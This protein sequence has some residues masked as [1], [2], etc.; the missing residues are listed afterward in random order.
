MELRTR[1]LV[2]RP[3]GRGDHAVLV[4]I[5]TDPELM[6]HIHTGVPH[7]FDECSDDLE[8]AT[9]AWD[10]DGFGP[11]VAELADGTLI[12]T[13]GFGRP[14]WCPEAMPGP[15]VGWTVLQ[16]H[17]RRGYATE[18]AAASI[19]WF[20]RAGL[21][22]HLVGIHNTDNPASG[23]VMRRLGMRWLRQTIHPQC[24]YPIELWETTPTAWDEAQRRLRPSD[25]HR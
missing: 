9:I 22:T 13:V 1:R 16:A 21:G 14:T 10:Q 2:L 17:Q 12:G 3:L 6:R 18:A 7:R 15:D 5:N 8:R 19:S 25:P 4:R 24:Q 11:F 20:F 23:A